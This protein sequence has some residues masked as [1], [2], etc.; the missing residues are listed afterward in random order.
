[1]AKKSK[2]GDNVKREMLMWTPQMDEYFIQAMLTQQYHGNR[3][4]GTFTSSAYTNMVN[5]LHEKLNMDFNHEVWN[6]LIAAK[7]DANKWKTKKIYNYNELEELFAKDR[8]TGAAD[9]TAKEKKNS[10]QKQ[11]LTN[12]K[13]L[14]M[15]IDFCLLTK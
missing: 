5:E 8:A 1:M 13:H 10:G 15:L 3:I 14:R 4:D 2:E 12:Q 6:D 7:P 9:G 11:L